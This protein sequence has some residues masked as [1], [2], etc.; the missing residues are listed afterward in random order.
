M[1][2]A[3]THREKKDKE[4]RENEGMHSQIDKEED[5]TFYILHPLINTVKEE[6]ENEV[7]YSN[8]V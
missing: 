1:E 2:M 6:E 8:L 4:L 7:G 5:H 3:F